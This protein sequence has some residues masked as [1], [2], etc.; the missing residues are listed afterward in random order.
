MITLTF[1]QST[2][3]CVTKG[4]MQA[5]RIDGE[6]L[7]EEPG[8]R[9]IARHDDHYW[10]VDCERYLRIDCPA[11]V[12]VRFEGDRG[13]STQY[14]PFNHLSFG[15]GICFVEHELFA[16]FHADN[17]R[18]FSHRNRNYWSSIVV[19]APESARFLR[20]QGK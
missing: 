19:C 2:P 17:G 5:F 4:P 12:L 3:V 20:A 13:P 16:T 15:D 9:A 6:T 7:Y 18:W 10:V 1:W 11:A 8:Q 14:G